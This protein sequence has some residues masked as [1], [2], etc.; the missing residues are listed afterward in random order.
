M[1][2]T[3]RDVWY[4]GD[5]L[6]GG[7]DALTGW[8]HP[9]HE[10]WTAS[11]GY[12]DDGDPQIVSLGISNL[13]IL[14]G[15]GELLLDVAHREVRAVRAVEGLGVQINVAPAMSSRP[16]KWTH[17]VVDQDARYL[18]GSWLN[19]ST[20]HHDGTQLNPLHWK[21]EDYAY[22][23]GRVVTE[24]ARCDSTLIGVVI[25]SRE[26]LR[27]PTTGIYGSSGQPLADALKDLGLHSSALADIG[28][29]YE[30]WYKRRNLAAHG[31]RRTDAD[32]RPSSNVYKPKKGSR[33]RPP[34]VLFEI[35]EQDFRDLA[36]I[37]S[38]FYFLYHDAFRV[39]LY[40]DASAP[41][42]ST[43]PLLTEVEAQELLKQ[44]PMPNSVHES[45]RLP[46]TGFTSY[47]S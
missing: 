18:E 20:H 33:K 40:L 12:N 26:L 44:I 31:F 19:M 25:S 43:S 28:E 41:L 34:D 10:I 23:V 22:Y 14:N 36:M 21:E 47:P 46:S 29:R 17:C 32:G 9:R 8:G 3:G 13:Q 1:N 42:A 11:A 15:N 35:E 39:L 2:N 27:Q 6:A 5:H 16:M 45:E 24:G 30:A 7:I 37:W 38:A 4:E